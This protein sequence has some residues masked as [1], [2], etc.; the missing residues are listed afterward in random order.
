MS[1]LINQREYLVDYPV[2]CG[3][4][5]MVYQDDNID[6]V[7]FR[8]NPEKNLVGGRFIRNVVL[9]NYKHL[10]INIGPI[11]EDDLGSWEGQVIVTDLRSQVRFEIEQV[12]LNG[13]PVNK[14][15]IDNDFWIG[16]I[17]TE[18]SDGSTWVENFD[19]NPGNRGIPY[20]DNG[21]RVIRVRPEGNED[22]W[23]DLFLVR[24]LQDKGYY[25]QYPKNV[26]EVK[27]DGEIVY[28]VQIDRVL[29]L[30]YNEEKER[31]LTAD[32]Q[33]VTFIPNE[34]ETTAIQ[35][36]ANISSSH[37]QFEYTD[38]A[39]VV[40]ELETYRDILTGIRISGSFTDMKLVTFASSRHFDLM[41]YFTVTAP[42][43]WEINTQDIVQ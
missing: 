39:G 31:Y 3:I 33:A 21:Y 2:D 16:H 12:K 30:A 41:P 1:K 23:Y 20:I 7:N 11:A 32:G 4:L 40:W 19:S 14:S 28:P 29:L 38:N 6:R 24:R 5:E 8:D 15:D 22:A 17:T 35:K 10:Y 43:K 37:F 18:Y 9:G 34:A 26:K 13:K 42:V 36:I 27:I 25:G